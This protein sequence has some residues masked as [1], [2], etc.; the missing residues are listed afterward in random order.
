MTPVADL[1]RGLS[2][3]Q[4]ADLL[5]HW[6]EFCDA[7]PLSDGRDFDD[8]IEGMEAAGFAELVAVDD[9]ALNEAF[10]SERGIEPGGMMW[11]LT[12]LGLLV[13]AHLEQSK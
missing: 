11:R 5:Q 10:A 6:D 7:D 9:D 12:P 8:F 2:E 3:A 4:K 1:A 13:R